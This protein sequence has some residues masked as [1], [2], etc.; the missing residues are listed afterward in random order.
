MHME[1]ASLTHR[2]WVRVQTL[3]LWLFTMPALGDLHDPPSGIQPANENTYTYLEGIP[4]FMGPAGSQ[5]THAGLPYFF[6][7]IAVAQLDDPLRRDAGIHRGDRALEL[8]RRFVASENRGNYLGQGAQ[9]WAGATEFDR[10]DARAAFLRDYESRLRD[11]APSL[12]VVFGVAEE[13][14][15]GDY[16]ADRGGFPIVTSQMRPANIDI[17]GAG[18]GWFL[19]AQTREL[20][21][22]APFWEIDAG[23]AR[24]MAARFEGDLRPGDRTR[25]PRTVRMV[26]FFEATSVDAAQGAVQIRRLHT[27]IY[28]H[29][30]GERLHRLPDALAGAAVVRGGRTSPPR[31]TG[32]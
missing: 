4:V 15:V 28:D 24:A 17:H 1:T 8:A 14:R 2:R 27:D 7:L 31:A 19:T 25:R 18:L 9:N 6:D 11:M 5:G 26:A 23:A 30:L 3:L 32:T 12:P 22:P 13:R 10:A 20:E 16:D 29:G 21:L